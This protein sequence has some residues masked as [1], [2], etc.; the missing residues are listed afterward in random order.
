MKFRKL[1]NSSLEASA[2]GLGCMAMTNIYGAADE[3]ESI[4]T[5]HHALDSGGQPAR[6]LRRL[7]Q[8]QERGIRRPRHRRP[9]GR[10]DPGHD[11][12]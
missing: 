2:I 1:G 10:G 8:R 11:S 5:V 6:H 4:A 3:A 12:V 7:R 9:Q